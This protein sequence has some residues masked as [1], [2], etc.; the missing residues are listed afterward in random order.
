MS[1]PIATTP[2]YKLTVPST[3]KS[4][5]FRPFLVKEE[6]ALMIAQQSDDPDVM[7]TTLKSVIKACVP[8]IKVE[9]LA[10][11]DIE[12]IFTQLR[13]KSVG[14][15]VDL[16]LKCDTCVDEKASVS[17]NIDLTKLEVQIPED[18]NK[19]IPLY[20]D[21][22]LVM[23]YPSLDVLRRI[24]N[25]DGKD[26]DSVFDIIYS[27]IEHIYTSQEMFA[28][29]DQKFDD[30]KEF[31][32]NLTREQFVKIQK[33]FESMPKLEHRVK[34]KCPL[35]SKEHDKMIRGLDSFF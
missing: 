15:T 26:V 19:T 14:E 13:A 3:K 9:D 1:L 5:S 2:L 10:I 16:I 20:N 24:E 35:C 29:K 34:Y 11:F 27:C 33:F 17:Y 25:I 32:D 23:R 18:H 12:Y 8:D 22:G 4:L 7:I 21:V 31:V 28:A 6:K 30:V